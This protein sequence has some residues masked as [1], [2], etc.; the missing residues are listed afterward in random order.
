MKKR[1]LPVCLHYCSSSVM[2]WHVTR[3]VRPHGADSDSY[4]HICKGFIV[5]LDAKHQAN[6]V[7]HVS[8]GPWPQLL[9]WQQKCMRCKEALGR[10]SD[11]YGCHFTVP[12][13]KRPGLIKTGGFVFCYKVFDTFG[14]HRN[15]DQNTAETWQTSFNLFRARLQDIKW[16]EL[17]PKKRWWVLPGASEWLQGYQAQ[18]LYLTAARWLIFNA[19]TW[20]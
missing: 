19:E 16:K 17:R 7:L 8:W 9:P 1:S 20:K 2:M 6:R 15:W 11:L 4:K 13:K 3:Q 10:I 5:E 12:T 14:P 18:V